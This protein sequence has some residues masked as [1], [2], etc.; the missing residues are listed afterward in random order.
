M[1][2]FLYAF[3]CFLHSAE[4]LLPLERLLW[5]SLDVLL[6][7]DSA[8]CKFNGTSYTCQEFFVVVVLCLIT[9]VKQ[10]TNKKQLCLIQLGNQNFYDTLDTN[11]CSIDILPMNE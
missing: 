2:L 9:E 11:R 10:Q 7:S 6:Y 1:A 3:D 8:L 5:H 4:A